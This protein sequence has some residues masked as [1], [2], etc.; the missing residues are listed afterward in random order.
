MNIEWTKSRLGFWLLISLIPA[1]IAYVPA[2]ALSPDEPFQD[3]FFWSFIGTILAL[4]LPCALVAG[5]VLAVWGR[6]EKSRQYREAQHYAQ[7]HGWHPISKTTWRNRK[8]NGVQLSVD[9]AIVGSTYILT[10]EINGETTVVDEFET[11]T[12]ALEFGDWL[13]EEL[14]QA[15]GMTPD[16]EVV[17]E[18]RA[19]WEQSKGLTLYRGPA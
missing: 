9:K 6:I 4:Y 10:I 18:K 14:L 3:E 16:V 19:E 1:T 2:A 8:R 11:P 5:A 13:W 17:A 15:Q 12:W 7:R